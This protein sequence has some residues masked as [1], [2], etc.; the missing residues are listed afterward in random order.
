MNSSNAL[1]MLAVLGFAGLGCGGARGPPSP[2]GGVAPGPGAGPVPAAVDGG[3]GP[4]AA[5]A[6]APAEASNHTSVRVGPRTITADT[7]VSASCVVQGRR[8]VVGLGRR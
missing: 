6:A 3:A 7:G 2:P 5:T 8:A 4:E 1:P